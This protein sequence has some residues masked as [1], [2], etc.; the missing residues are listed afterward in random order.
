M[1]A[2]PSGTRRRSPFCAAEPSFIGRDRRAS[3][4]APA[5]T[6]RP[7]WAPPALRGRTGEVAYEP[8]G[9]G[10]AEP[11]AVPLSRGG[12]ATSVTAS[13]PERAGNAETPGPR[14]TAALRPGPLLRPAAVADD[15]SLDRPGRPDKS[16][17]RARLEQGRCR[18]HE[19]R[20][21]GDA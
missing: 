6:A 8:V 9:S 16:S 4:M 13:T 2:T 17:R 21:A 3:W 15:E 1:Y 7:S 12:A 5:R 18:H 19:D 10:E 20:P 11:R 14:A